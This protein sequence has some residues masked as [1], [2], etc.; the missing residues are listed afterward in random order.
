[1]DLRSHAGRRFSDIYDAL[2]V[3]FGPGADPERIREVTVLKFELERAQAAGTATLEDTVRVFNLVARK[4]KELRLA[5]ARKRQIEQTEGLRSKSPVRSRRARLSFAWRRA[6]PVSGAIKAAAPRR[7]IC[8]RR[9]TAGSV[10]AS[11]RLTSKRPGRCWRNS[12]RWDTRRRRLKGL[13]GE[14]DQW[15]RSRAMT[16]IGAS[17]PLRHRPLNRALPALRPLER[18]DSARTGSRSGSPEHH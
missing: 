17:F 10:R 2:A 7:S 8:S 18:G 15:P 5:N 3:E 1:M 13:L 14:F 12:H 11:I 16:A 9:S 6:S 4:E